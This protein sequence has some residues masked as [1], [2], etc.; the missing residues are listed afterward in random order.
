MM[1]EIVIPATY[2]YHDGTGRH[3]TTD[4]WSNFFVSCGDWH[5]A[6]R[7]LDREW[8]A[9]VKASRN[10]GEIGTIVFENEQDATMF[11]LRWA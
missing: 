3:T 6:K 1:T 10:L 5:E 11:L 9:Q 2:R 7:V 8:N 4:W